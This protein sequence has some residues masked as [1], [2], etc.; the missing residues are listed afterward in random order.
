MEKVSA[1]VP[2]YREESSPKTITRSATW[3]D[4]TPI[5]LVILYITAVAILLW[6]TCLKQKYAVKT[7][8]ERWSITILFGI[9]FLYIWD[10]TCFMTI[11]PI[12]FMLMDGLAS[13]LLFM[14]SNHAIS[15]SVSCS[16]ILPVQ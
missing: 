2:T 6:L 8:K 3:K 10:Y 7:G 5:P 12:P 13:S 15:T 1:N 4:L 14:I 9:G 11:K 16:H